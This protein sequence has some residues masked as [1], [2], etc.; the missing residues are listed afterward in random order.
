L[1]DESGGT[2]AIGLT[3]TVVSEVAA[4][5]IDVCASCEDPP[6][7]PQDIRKN[8]QDN[9]NRLRTIGFLRA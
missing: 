7:P 1:F 6:P 2:D 4:V 9:G 5:L 8:A 3:G